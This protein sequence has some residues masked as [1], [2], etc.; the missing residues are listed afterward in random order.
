MNEYYHVIQIEGKGLGCVALKKIR[1]GTMILQEKPQLIVVDN[2]SESWIIE[3]M[4]SYNDMNEA[5]QDEY[6]KLYNRFE[7][8]N[9]LN[10]QDKEKISKKKKWLE[11]NGETKER[12]EVGQELMGIYET[13]CFENGVGIQASRFN[14]SCCSNAEHHW[15]E[16]TNS[17][18]FRVISKVN[19]GD[20]ITVNYAMPFTM[21]SFKKRQDNLFEAWGFVCQCDLCKEEIKGTMHNN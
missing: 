15:N 1:I 6:W 7:N 9:G 20:E 17:R 3:V 19:P 5:D 16:K 18:E 2:S 4:N 13:N 8:V 11:E 12:I 14:H 10:D 21:K